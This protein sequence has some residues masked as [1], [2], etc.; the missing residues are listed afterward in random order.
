MKRF[1]LAIF[2]MALFALPVQAA[3]AIKIVVPFPAGGSTDSAARVIA[4]AL[5][6]VLPTDDF[7]VENKFGGNGM[8]AGNDVLSANPAGSKLM[9]AGSGSLSSPF[10]L[11][12][13]QRPDYSLKD[14]TPIC[15][16]GRFEVTIV[17][18]TSSPFTNMKAVV[19]TAR[20]HPGVVTFAYG[21]STNLTVPVQLEK[22]AG[23]ELN[24]VPFRS[25][26]QILNAVLGGHISVGQLTNVVV[27][28]NAKAGTVRV[29]AILSD[30]RS[31][32]LPD[33]PTMTEVDEN[34]APF[35]PWV[36][37]VGPATMNP[38]SAKRI[39]DACVK[40]L[41]TDSVTKKLEGLGFEPMDAKVIG[42]DGFGNFMRVQYEQWQKIGKA[43]GLI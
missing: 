10:I 21:N 32:F 27:A 39:A 19:A 37:L 23:L 22:V 43:V 16:V 35:T 2:A 29:L 30:K 28:G 25:E 33:V 34:W 38:E 15:G 18:K 5:M 40:V 41:A 13:E 17:V 3:E 4:D 6:Q 26:T 8:I 1:P 42:R 20:Q 36:G 9:M 7:V 14:F 24:K 12:K 11:P 31:R